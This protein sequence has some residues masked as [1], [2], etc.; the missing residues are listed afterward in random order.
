[1]ISRNPAQREE[2]Q[3]WYLLRLE[4]RRLSELSS[5]SSLLINQEVKSNKNVINLKIFTTIAT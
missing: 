4:I 2:P 5:P 1:M 3:K